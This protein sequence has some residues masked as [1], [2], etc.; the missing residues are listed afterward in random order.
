MKPVIRLR[1]CLAVIQDGRILMV[2]HTVASTNAQQWRIPGGKVAFGDD[3]RTAVLCEFER[4]TGFVAEC[5]TLLDVYESIR[6]ERALH[7]ITF[8]Y[9]GNII[10]GQLRISQSSDG[11]T[12]PRW[13]TMDELHTVKYY[14]PRIV[15]KALFFS[16]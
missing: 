14:P 4:Q 15:E 16:W 10:G 1:T 9:S 2:P 8:A 5:G 6:P 3:L 12:T 7:S 11:E 13:F